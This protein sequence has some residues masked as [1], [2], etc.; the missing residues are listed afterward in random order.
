MAWLPKFP[1]KVNYSHQS[2]TFTRKQKTCFN[3]RTSLKLPSVH[4]RSFNAYI[5]PRARVVGCW[6]QPMHCQ[7]RVFMTY[8]LTKLSLIIIMHIQCC[9]LILLHV[10]FCSFFVLVCVQWDIDSAALESWHVGKSPDS[11]ALA[12]L[13]KHNITTKHR[14]RQVGTGKSFLCDLYGN[15]V[16]I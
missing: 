13:A 12:C 14:G 1:D 15:L 16:E 8:N 7:W 2:I 9:W 11:R 10:Y 4:N 3:D 6:L 5:L